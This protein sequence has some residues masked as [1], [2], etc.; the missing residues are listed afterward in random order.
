VEIDYELAWADLKAEVLRKPS[1]GQRDLLAKM[2]ELEVL[3]RTPSGAASLPPHPATNG[4]STTGA[5][6][7][8]ARA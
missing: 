6:R 4:H 7:V 5:A 2:G 1:H 3:H 8:A